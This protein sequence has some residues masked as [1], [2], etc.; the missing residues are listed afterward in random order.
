MNIQAFVAKYDL[1]YDAK[2]YDG[3]IITTLGMD[4]HQFCIKT[5][6]NELDEEILN[7]DAYTYIKYECIPRVQSYVKK[8]WLTVK[9][10]PF[11]PFEQIWFR[12]KLQSQLT[13]KDVD[14]YK[15]GVVT[16]ID[17]LKE[18][19]GSAFFADLCEVSKYVSD[20]DYFDV[21]EYM[22]PSLN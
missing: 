4:N 3:Y 16:F 22:K 11:S 17:I 8:R 2:I 6:Y 19:F 13:K 9:N 18:I 10:Q 21:Y 1:Y 7:W 20:A 15:H 14:A 5:L 12:D